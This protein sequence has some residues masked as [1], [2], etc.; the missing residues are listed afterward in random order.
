MDPHKDS[1]PKSRPP[2]LLDQA[3]DKLRT[4]HYS[5]RT[6]RQYVQW[7]H[8]FILF[9]DKRHPRTMGVSEL[10]AFLTHLAVTRKV[11]AAT[12]NQTLAAL[13]FLYQK[14]L[15][16]EPPWLKDVVRAKPSRHLPVVLTHKN[17][18]ARARRAH[19]FFGWED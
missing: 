4:L 16:L 6:E 7:I 1:N 18:K 5:Y 10:E 19:S 9:H 14:L 12:Q 8:R 17:E 2:R 13:L 3:R 15:E 11:S